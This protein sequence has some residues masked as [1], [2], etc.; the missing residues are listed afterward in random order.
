M[1]GYVEG[2]TGKEGEGVG[3]EKKH[4]IIR[5]SPNNEN[6]IADKNRHSEYDKEPKDTQCTQSNTRVD[7]M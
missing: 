1:D 7:T 3:E 6:N 2:T 4:D 5:V